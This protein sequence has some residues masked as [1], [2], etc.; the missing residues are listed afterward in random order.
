MISLLIINLVRYLGLASGRGSA[1]TPRCA[2][3]ER[4]R[5]V[6]S[7]DFE[8]SIGYLV[9]T[10]SH[11]IEQALNE[12]LRE[13]GIT[14]RQWQVLA[15]L[16]LMGDSASQGDIAQRLG[17]ESATLVGV[18]D[19]MERDGWIK[20][21]PCPTDRRKKFIRVTER[22]EPVWQTMAECGHRVREKATV[23]VSTREYRLAW[24]V[25]EQML[26]NLQGRPLQTAP[27]SAAKEA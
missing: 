10:T 18:L 2:D 1:R 6:I 7:Y 26:V 14:F 15:C 4:T 3:A 22:V 20:R 12:E 19:R 17:I 23:G 21:H 25:L 16:A 11:A 8:E 13:Y 24:K 9:H 5:H 27:I